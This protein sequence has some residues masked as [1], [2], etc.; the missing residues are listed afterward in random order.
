VDEG[1][2]GVHEIELVVNAG[3]SLCDGSGVRDH[4]HSSLHAGKISSGDDGRRLVVDAALEAGR[5]PIHELD[6]SLGLDGGDSRIDIL[7]DD[8]SSEH[9]AA[10]HELSVARVA[11][12]EHIGWLEDGVGDLG[13]REL[14]VVGFL[15]RDDRSVRG[16]HKVDARVRH[17]V[18]LELG[19]IDVEGA[20]ETKGGGEGRHDLS[21]QSIQVGVG[22]SL[23]IKRSA[24][25]V[26]EGL[27]IE[28]EGAVSVL[29]ESVR[30]KH[31]VV[32]LDD[33]G[34]DLRS[35]GDGEGKLGLAAVVDRETLEKERAESRAS[36]TTGS[37]ENHKALETGAVIGELSD[38]IKDKIDNLLANGVVATGVVVGGVFLAGD[39]LL[40]VVE[41]AVGS[42]SN[43]IKRS[44]FEIDKH[45]SR[46][47]F[48]STSL[49]EKGVERVIATTDGFVGRHLAIG[50]DAVLQ[51]VE[52][53]AAVTHLNAG[54]T[55]VKGKNFSHVD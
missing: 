34:G 28:T 45:S 2:L 23:N 8:V 36:T 50:L 7:G 12:G 18:G 47:V 25:H 17:Q 33:G 14:L 6:G 22:R 19:N 41:L 5:A 4:A 37:M 27:V 9:H 1:T 35:R 16:K 20:V 49:G 26:I 11:L 38:S 43:L 53:P 21:D 40:R 10:S 55:N 42:G 44:R 32:R 51:A 39:E 24:A 31:V 29:K 54:L 13:N 46:H 52:L 3:K 30:G 15:G 48:A